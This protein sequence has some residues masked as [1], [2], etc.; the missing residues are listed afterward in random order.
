MAPPQQAEIEKKIVNVFIADIHNF[1]KVRPLQGQEGPIA[2]TKK[3]PVAK[4]KYTEE[5][6]NNI[7]R[8]HTKDN[9]LTFAVCTLQ[10]R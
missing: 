4:D 1:K 3:L 9:D 2:I 10:P 6:F 7:L 5:E 8:E